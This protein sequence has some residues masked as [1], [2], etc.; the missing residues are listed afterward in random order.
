MHAV[1]DP[2]H[3]GELLNDY[4]MI[5]YDPVLPGTDCP[6]TTPQTQCLRENGSGWVLVQPN[7]PGLSPGHC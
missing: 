5:G 7:T 6:V 1:P 2:Q 3:P 4:D